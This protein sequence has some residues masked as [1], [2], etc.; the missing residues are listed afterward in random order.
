MRSFAHAKVYLY[1]EHYKLGYITF[2]L[3]ILFVCIVLE[4]EWCH[5]HLK[6]I[7]V[8]GPPQPN[9]AFDKKYAVCRL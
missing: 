9:L 8:Y 7:I 6:S 2:Y 3:T 1:F 4:C 5:Y